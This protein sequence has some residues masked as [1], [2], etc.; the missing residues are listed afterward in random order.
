[1]AN[2]SCIRHTKGRQTP[3]TDCT[4]VLSYTSPSTIGRY[5]Y[6][7][8]LPRGTDSIL[9]RRT[10]FLSSNVDVSKYIEHSVKVNGRC[11]RPS[12]GSSRVVKSSPIQSNSLIPFELEMRG[13]L[14]K[15]MTSWRVIFYCIAALVSTFCSILTAYKTIDL[16][17][18]V[19][20]RDSTSPFFQKVRSL[21]SYE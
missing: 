11:K 10:N 15:I 8:V 13:T 20:G 3:S 4:L 12:H 21:L 1:M 14:G 5:Q 9:V 17:V 19:H 7:T 2:A 18:N 16:D 6:R